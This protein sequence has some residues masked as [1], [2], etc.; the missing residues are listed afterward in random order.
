MITAE[1][2]RELLRYD[3]DTGE[4]YWL[5][6]RGR[7]KAGRRA[8]CIMRPKGYRAIC[9]DTKHYLAHRLAWLYVYGEWPSGDLD[10]RD[11]DPDNNRIENL[12]VAERWQNQANR[13][14]KANRTGFPGIQ[15][16]D[17]CELWSALI[18]MNG[19]RHYLGCFKSPEDA[20]D[21]YHQAY[22][23]YAG[24]FARSE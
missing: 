3:P 23:K 7:I 17:G 10:H 20:S 12:R 6:G 5:R 24:E 13:R 15:K 2:L 16:V 1:R 19:K 9:I 14:Q 21:A 22:R 8:G 4:F 18:H 11:I